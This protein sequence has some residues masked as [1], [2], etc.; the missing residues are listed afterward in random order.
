MLAEAPAMEVVDLVA[1]RRFVARNTREVVECVETVARLAQ[2]Q[3]SN[4]IKLSAIIMGSLQM[5]M[6]PEGMDYYDCAIVMR[7]LRSRKIWSHGPQ[8]RNWWR[9]QQRKL[10]KTPAFA[11]SQTKPP[12]WR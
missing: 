3:M 10:A 8:F 11:A 2:L 5:A 7:A 6:P 12:C 4:D 1:W 9:S